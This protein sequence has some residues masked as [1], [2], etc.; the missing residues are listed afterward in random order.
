MI[1]RGPGAAGKR[2]GS[3]GRR[4]R[5]S[6][7]AATSAAAKAASSRALP[8]ENVVVVGRTDRVVSAGLASGSTVRRTSREAS[9]TSLR[10]IR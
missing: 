1:G 4:R 10:R 6:S 2:S 3:L 5:R 8:I 9:T 7:A